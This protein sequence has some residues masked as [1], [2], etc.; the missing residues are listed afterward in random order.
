METYE[1]PVWPDLYEEKGALLEENQ[2]LYAVLQIDKRE[3]TL[4]L[5]CR[6]LEDLTKVN[7]EIVEACDKAYDRAKLQAARHTA[8]LKPITPMN[9]PEK[10]KSKLE[11]KLDIRQTRLTHILKLK[12]TLLAYP[13]PCTVKLQFYV[14]KRCVGT[15]H[16]A[17]GVA[18]SPA[19]QSALKTLPCLLEM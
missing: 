16:L 2:L 4:R 8:T 13:G 18:F 5:S 19:L 6:W 17:G 12:E 3:E 1:L 9:E 7:E 10:N 14:A 15:L 11:L